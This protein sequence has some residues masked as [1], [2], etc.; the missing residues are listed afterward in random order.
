MAIPASSYTVVKL[1]CLNTLG[2][3]LTLSEAYSYPTPV[4][5]PIES[6]IVSSPMHSYVAIQAVLINDYKEK[7]KVVNIF[8]YVV[9]D[10]SG[11]SITI[12]SYEQLE[13]KQNQSYLFED[14]KV[15]TYNSQKQLEF[16]ATP[17]FPT[18]M[19]SPLCLIHYFILLPLVYCHSH[20]WCGNFGVRPLFFRE[21]QKKWMFDVK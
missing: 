9:R 13:L 8:K 20:A 14:L 12:C 6:V 19:P 16:G 10:N 11:E 5:T 1:S 21:Y 15:T 18:L 7:P 17:E 3:I 2:E 4:L